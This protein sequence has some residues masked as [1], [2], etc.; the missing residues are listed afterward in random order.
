MTLLHWKKMYLVSFLAHDD[1]QLSLQ[2]TD[3]VICHC[4]AQSNM[5]TTQIN[6][7]EQATLHSNAVSNMLFAEVCSPEVPKF[8]CR[9]AHL[10]ARGIFC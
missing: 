8:D 3:A 1:L 10:Q 5:P 2:H 4:A 9:H 6:M 7:K